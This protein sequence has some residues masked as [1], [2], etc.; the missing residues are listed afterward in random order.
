MNKPITVK[1][2]SI[3]SS[4]PVELLT[5]GNNLY[6]RIL[7][8]RKW[9]RQLARRHEL[10]TSRPK[11]RTELN[12]R[13]ALQKKLVWILS[14][15][16][17]LL[18]A[19]IGMTWYV[20]KRIRVQKIASL[21]K[22]F[23]ADLHDELGANLYSIGLLS[24]LARQSKMS[25]EKLDDVH[26][27]IRRIVD[28]SGGA[29]RY[30]ADVEKNDKFCADLAEDMGRAAE[31]IVVHLEHDLQIQGEEHLEHLNAETRAGILLFYKECLVNICRHS[32]ATKLSTELDVTERQLCLKVKDNGCVATCQENGQPGK[33]LFE[34]RA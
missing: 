29:I 20:S 22:K 2:T 4:R 14:W 31:R 13:Y 7:P 32:E 24:D 33:A 8:M 11:L 6:G 3:L 26:N 27:R 17:G 34:M 25:N 9:L 30:W 28:R 18:V 19:G 10:E 15:L 21:R 23:A 1:N 16:A 12:E 5:D